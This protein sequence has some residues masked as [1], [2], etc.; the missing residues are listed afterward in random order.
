M[1][2]I[3]TWC[4]LISVVS[5]AVGLILALVPDSKLKASYKTMCSLIVI[6]A[7]FSTV[8]SVNTNELQI[9]VDSA[10][11]SV[12]LNEA[13]DE[14][15]EKEGENLLAQSVEKLLSDNNITA[16]CEADIKYS[17]GEMITEKIMIYGSFSENE[18]NVIGDLIKDMLGGG[19]NVVF[20]V[21]V[22]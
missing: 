20:E 16:E 17:E 18:K 2:K 12:S 15:L 9:T 5:I 10:S 6:Y 7:V 4:K 13:G 14:L 21:K 22:E 8:T 3:S 19:T 1:E 11:A